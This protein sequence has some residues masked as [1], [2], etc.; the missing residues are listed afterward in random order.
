M[1]R[2]LLAYLRVLSVSIKSRSDGETQ[3][4]MTV[5]LLPPRES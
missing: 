4:I 3:A 1:F 5:R 2:A